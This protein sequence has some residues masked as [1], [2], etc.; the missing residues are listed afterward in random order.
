MRGV[1]RRFYNSSNEPAFHTAHLGAFWKGS[2]KRLQETVPKFPLLNLC[3][4]GFNWYLHKD[5][6]RQPLN[7]QWNPKKTNTEIE[8]CCSSPLAFIKQLEQDPSCCYAI[9]PSGLRITATSSS[10]SPSKSQQSQEKEQI[11]SADPDVY[12]KYTHGK[13][14]TH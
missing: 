9:Y 7:C 11:P 13:P 12:P 10:L 3:R 8:D 4:P 6:L 5:L 1:S 2:L 14:L